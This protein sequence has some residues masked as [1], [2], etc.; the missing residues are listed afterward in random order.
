M[1]VDDLSSANECESDYDED[2]DIKNKYEYNMIY[3]LI[4]CGLRRYCDAR[5]IIIV[6]LF[7]LAKTFRLFAFFNTHKST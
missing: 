2:E 4:I 7:C 5:S 6:I 3:K 1:D